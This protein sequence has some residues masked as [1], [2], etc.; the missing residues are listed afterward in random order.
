MPM[1]P[2]LIKQ[3]AYSYTAALAASEHGI[4]NGHLYAQVAMP[5][6]ANIDEHNAALEVLKEA[7]LISE[8]YYLLTWTGGE[9]LAKQINAAMEA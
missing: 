6:D 2:D 7:G 1:K 4:P 5:L 9:E 3:L 8:E